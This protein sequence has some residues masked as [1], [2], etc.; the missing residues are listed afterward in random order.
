[1]AI[2]RAV[3]PDE[4]NSRI[5]RFTHARARTHIISSFISHQRIRVRWNLVLDPCLFNRWIKCI[6]F[7][8]TTIFVSQDIHSHGGWFYKPTGL[9]NLP[10]TTGVSVITSVAWEIPPP[11]AVC[12]MPPIQLPTLFLPS[13]HQP[14]CRCWCL[15]RQPWTWRGVR[16]RKR[17][18]C[19]SGP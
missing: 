13:N 7:F 5:Q 3:V 19:S 11:P 6:D 10:V 18:R 16:T 4:T 14:C 1:M 8:Q 12:F 9:A 2:N 15:E 17:P